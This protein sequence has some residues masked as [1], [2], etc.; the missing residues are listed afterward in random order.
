[1]HGED[2]LRQISFE[3]NAGEFIGLIGPNGAGKTTLLRSIMNFISYSGEVVIDGALTVK[4][5]HN[6]RAKWLSY[7]PQERDV[8]W[9]VSVETI[10]GL[11]RHMQRSAFA[12][13]SPDD[14]QVIAE[15]MAQMDVTK[16]AKKSVQELSGGEKARVLIARLLAQ[17]SP[18]I[19]ADEPVSGLDPAHQLSLMQCFAELAQ[20]GKT[21]IASLHDLSL[22]A[23]RCTRL[24]M[25]EKGRIIADGTPKAVLTAENLRNVYKIEADI[26]FKNERIYIQPETVIAH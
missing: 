17:G 1:M 8:A 9:P 5:A 11:G 4:M 18:L 14:H 19:L 15:A 22:S 2:I 26:I 23:H 3:A 16:F 20:A 7:L 12:S 13:L 6:E 24:I 10:V 25:L 21:V